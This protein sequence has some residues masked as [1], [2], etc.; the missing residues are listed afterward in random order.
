LLHADPAMNGSLLVVGGGGL[1][2]SSL[3]RTA[4]TRGVR[5]VITT[6]TGGG[7]SLALDLA[8]VPDDWRP[9]ENFKVAVFCA[10]ATGIQW[11]REHPDLARRINATNTAKLARSLADAGT[12]VVLLST[13]LVFDGEIPLPPIDAPCSP[14]TVYGESKTEAESAFRAL[15]DRAAVVRL[16]KV[17]HP[18]I[19]PMVHWL[20][21]LNRAG[22]IEAFDDYRCSPVWIDEVL[23]ALL[24][25]AT[26]RLAGIHHISPREEPSY[27]EIARGLADRIGADQDLVG[28]VAGRDTLPNLPF[29]RHTALD[30]S[31]TAKR[32]G[33]RIATVPEVLDRFVD[34]WRA[35]PSTAT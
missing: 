25:I 10:A 18:G 28:A 30:G 21:R 23:E 17:F 9:A 24:I 12:F 8:E 3:A 1:I 13:N 19:T 2:G 7:D 16:S 11:C 33:I 15:G 32:L 29:P 14:R 4:R 22:S 5:T 31:A 20:G 34:S 27:A 6:R 35:I 26:G